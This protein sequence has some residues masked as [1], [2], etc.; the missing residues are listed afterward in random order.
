[1]FVYVC[2]LYV[3]GGDIMLFWHLCQFIV[4][5]K[6]RGPPF[7]SFLKVLILTRSAHAGSS[8]NRSFPI[9]TMNHAELD[10]LD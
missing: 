1:M 10:E 7:D 5:P 3:C 4:T 8:N 6:K 9:W 2:C